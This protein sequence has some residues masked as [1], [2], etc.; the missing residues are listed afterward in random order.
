VLVN[1]AFVSMMGLEGFSTANIPIA[2]GLRRILPDFASE[3]VYLP[4]AISG[5]G[6]IHG[7]MFTVE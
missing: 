3:L 5:L 2:N 4:I 1:I 6:A 7:A